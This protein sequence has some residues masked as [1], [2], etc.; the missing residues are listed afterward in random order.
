MTE[1]VPTPHAAAA[2]SS[3]AIARSALHLLLGQVAMTALS[4]FISA[5][6]GRSLGAADYGVLYLASSIAAFAFVF[7][8]WGQTL[9]V[10]REVARHPE[11]AHE[12]LGTALGFRVVVT[13]GVTVLT[14]LTT[15]L[16]GYDLLIRGYT[17]LVIAMNLPYLLAAAYSLVFRGRERMDHYATVEVTNKVL[18]L[19]FILPAL[20]LGGRVG[21]VVLAQGLA[22]A[23]ALGVA[24]WLYRRLK[25]PSP[26][27]SAATG[28]ALVT[29]GAPMV[30]MT[31]AIS[32]QPYVD[33]VLLS[34]L[35]PA[36]AVGWYGA[37]KNFM[38][39]LNAPATILGSAAYPRLSRARGDLAQFRVEL[40]T[41]LRPL[42]VVGALGSVGTYL[43]ADLAV[44]LVYGKDKFA[45][46]I[47]V[48]QMFAPGL[49]LL[50]VD[51]LLGGALLALQKSRQLAV[52]KFLAVALGAGLDWFL[53]PWAQ[54]RHGNGGIGVVLSFSLAELVIIVAA[55]LLMPRGVLDR[56]VAWDVGKAALAGAG[57]LL[58]VR[59]VP[60]SSP[61]L[62]LPLYLATFAA[63]ALAFRLVT[64]GDLALLRSLGR[65]G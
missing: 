64:R 39:V 31:L 33:A 65:R 18:S 63:L 19:A 20:A 53:I 1:P 22:G 30:A 15:T 37:A 59:A 36:I 32:L 26:R 55:L 8:D 61:L 50:F 35:A 27:V 46:A 12:L 49:L 40:R 5:A 29:G 52:A 28:R 10:V 3:R 24:I 42:V 38:G 23:G 57:T 7:V 6:I 41:A 54:A 21:S 56:S 62:Q 25:M 16:L 13:A 44:S 60:V 17:A 11:L 9:Y 4:I 14:F 51:I 48:L 43:F 47:P 45:P 34:K 58:L 2:E